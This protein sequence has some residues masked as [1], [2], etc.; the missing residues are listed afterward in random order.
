MLFQ[1]IW[2]CLEIKLEIGDLEERLNAVGQVIA[3]SNSELPRYL[4]P[5]SYIILLD[6]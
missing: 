3:E 4:C 2:L 1:G 5:M 6:A